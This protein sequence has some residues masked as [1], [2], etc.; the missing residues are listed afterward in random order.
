LLLLLLLTA[1]R[2]YAHTIQLRARG[3]ALSPIA[4]RPLTN[5]C[6]IRRA[7]VGGVF[8]ISFRLVRISRRRA[9]WRP[10]SDIN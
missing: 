7:T 3:F 8:P 2:H 6:L 5:A 9:P 1:C 4:A 10:P